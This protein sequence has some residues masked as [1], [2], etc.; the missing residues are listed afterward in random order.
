MIRKI[1]KRDKESFLSMAEAFYR[2]DAVLHPIPSSHMRKTFKILME[3]SPFADAYIMETA[4]KAVGYILL[5]LTYSNEAGGMVLWIEELYV[6]P[7][8]RGRGAGTSLLA[9][10]EEKYMGAA[11]IRL[12]VEPDNGRA[13]ELYQKLGFSKLSYLQMIKENGWKEGL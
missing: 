12:E 9:Y 7:E 5:G 3:G 13:A 11:R 10:A 2:S 4:G 6:C 1:E 8:Y